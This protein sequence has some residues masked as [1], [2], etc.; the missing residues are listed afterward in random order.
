MTRVI[1]DR[2]LWCVT[3]SANLLTP[4]EGHPLERYSTDWQHTNIRLDA[5]QPHLFAKDVGP[6]V[7]LFHVELVSDERDHMTSIAK[8]FECKS[9]G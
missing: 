2:I 1:V 4:L 9:E 3:F 8:K 5:V 6:P 7:E